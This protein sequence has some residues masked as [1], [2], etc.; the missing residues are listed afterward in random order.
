MHND[1]FA[2]CHVEN[3][4]EESTKCSAYSNLPGET[5]GSGATFKVTRPAD[6]TAVNQPGRGAEGA[7]IRPK[8]RDVPL[9][10]PRSRRAREDALPEGANNMYQ[11]REGNAASRP[12]NPPANEGFEMNP[13]SA[14]DRRRNLLQFRQSRVLQEPTPPATA[15]RGFNQNTSGLYQ[16]PEPP[17]ADPPQRVPAEGECF[18]VTSPCKFHNQSQRPPDGSGVSPLVRGIAGGLDRRRVSP[19][20]SEDFI[21]DNVSPVRSLANATHFILTGRNASNGSSHEANGYG[22]PS[23]GSEEQSGSSGGNS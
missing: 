20:Q 7:I 22:D 9:P 15:E 8:C 14:E 2:W 6:Q 16:R 3:R 19:P 11:G 5:A 4:L 13:L 12:A 1:L 21:P 17:T 23:A 10:S 18:I